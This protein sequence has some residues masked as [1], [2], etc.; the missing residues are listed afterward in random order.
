MKMQRLLN[1]IPALNILCSGSFKRHLDAFNLILRFY[2]QGGIMSLC[3]TTRKIKIF[4]I[5]STFY[6]AVA[7]ACNF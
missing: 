4:I 2:V 6:R 7:S 1:N 3:K 5:F